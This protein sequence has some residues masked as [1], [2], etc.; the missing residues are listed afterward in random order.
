MIYHFYELLCLIKCEG[1]KI[2]NILWVPE[3]EKKR[4]FKCGFIND[5]LIKQ[6]KFFKHTF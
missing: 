2:K 4:E 5:L 3:E 6:I 1:E